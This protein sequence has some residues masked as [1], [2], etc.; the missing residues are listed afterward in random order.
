MANFFYLS[1]AKCSRFS[2]FFVRNFVT[3]EKSC[4]LWRKKSKQNRLREIRKRI[5]VCWHLQ[6][7]KRGRS[8]RQTTI[9]QFRNTYSQTSNALQN[10]FFWKQLI[11][12]Y[13]ARGSISTFRRLYICCLF[14]VSYKNENL[15]DL[16]LQKPTKS[17]FQAMADLKWV[18]YKF[19]LCSLKAFWIKEVI[20]QCDSTSKT[21]LLTKFLASNVDPW[22][23]LGFTNLGS[24]MYYFRNRA[25]RWR[26]CAP[27]GFP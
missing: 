19:F 26:W 14:E 21:A 4:F 1:M 25:V 24:N 6:Q 23:T 5:C 20:P 9:G 13:Q 10:G 12:M 7:V 22:N 3:G 16:S 18:F 2:A 17:Y 15:V 8:I 27:R 11:N